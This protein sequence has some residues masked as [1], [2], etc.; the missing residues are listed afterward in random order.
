MTE[1]RTW[2]TSEKRTP[3]GMLTTSKKVSRPLL[4]WTHSMD[5][6]GSFL[7]LLIMP[8]VADENAD[9]LLHVVVQGRWLAGLRP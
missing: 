8:T 5:P 7:A 1:F 3:D 6:L 4:L 2:M 9:L